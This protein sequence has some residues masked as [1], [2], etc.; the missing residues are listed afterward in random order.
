M[1]DNESVALFGE[2]LQFPDVL[3]TGLTTAAF[4][5]GMALAVDNPRPAMNAV[6]ALQNQPNAHV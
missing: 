2:A 3:A 6:S 1:A 5:T 4:G